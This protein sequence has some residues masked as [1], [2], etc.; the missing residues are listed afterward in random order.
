MEK[1]DAIKLI[2]SALG[3][4][5]TFF[6]TAEAYGLFANE[7]LLAEALAAMR[8]QVVIA[9]KFGFKEGIPSN[10]ADSRPEHIRRVADDSN[11]L[12]PDWSVLPASRPSEC[13][14]GGRSVDGEGPDARGQGEALRDVRSGVREHPTGSRRSAAYSML[15]R[16]SKPTG[17]RQ[18]KGSEEK[19]I[20]LRASER[21]YRALLEDSWIGI[22]MLSA[23]A[24]ILYSNQSVTRILGFWRRGISR[25]KCV[26][27]DPS[28]RHTIRAGGVRSAFEESGQQRDH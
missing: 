20:G 24:T 27:G 6:D 7:E 23:E 19:A 9:T 18:L 22:T 8:D 13:C 11:A 12:R 15:R 2:Q 1:Q 14:Y 16:K 17:V 3:L 28:R 10:G 21:R 25:A 5:V 4:G 26:Q